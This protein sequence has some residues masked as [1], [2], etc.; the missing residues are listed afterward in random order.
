MLKPDIIASM[1]LKHTFNQYTKIGTTSNVLFNQ[2]VEG[3]KIWFLP[4]TVVFASVLDRSGF[5]EA[6]ESMNWDQGT[7]DERRANSDMLWKALRTNKIQ[8]IGERETDILRVTSGHHYEQMRWASLASRVSS[9]VRTAP[10]ADCILP[11]FWGCHMP[12]FSNRTV[13]QNNQRVEW[14]FII[15]PYAD[16]NQLLATIVKSNGGEIRRIPYVNQEVYKPFFQVRD[17]E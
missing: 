3:D 5:F 9:I 1:I 8:E 15:T 11:Q 2:H 7:N 6:Y 14:T 4:Y 16:Y 17:P 12:V 10:Q 13:I